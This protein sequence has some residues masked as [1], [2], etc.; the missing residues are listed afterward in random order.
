MVI[1]TTKSHDLHHT[2]FDAITDD[3]PIKDGEQD[4]LNALTPTEVSSL[5]DAGCA[6]RRPA[7]WYRTDN[8]GADLQP[9]CAITA[10]TIE[11][12]IRNGSQIA[13]HHTCFEPDDGSRL[14]P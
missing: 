11:R 13:D 7:Q 8:M 14:R 9:K 10:A 1:G 5:T 3:S 4:G 6:C 2:E 12:C